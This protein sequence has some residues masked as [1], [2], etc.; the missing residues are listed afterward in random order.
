MELSLTVMVIS[1]VSLLVGIGV[2]ILLKGGSLMSI[3]D[4]VWGKLFKTPE[5]VAHDGNVST[6]KADVETVKAESSTM[7]ADIAQIKTDVAAMLPDVADLKTNLAAIVPIIVG[8]AA[9]FPVTADLGTVPEEIAALGMPDMS[10]WLECVGSAKVDN[11]IEVD[12]WS[13]FTVGSEVAAL[14]LNVNFDPAHFSFLVGQEVRGDDIVDWGQFGVNE[15]TP[16]QLIIGA[17]RNAARAIVGDKPVHLASF[18][19]QVTTSN[20]ITSTVHADNYVD[21]LVDCRPLPATAEILLN[22]N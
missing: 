1:F 15:A 16:G 22:E 20:F 5:F 21:A 9:Q 13:K 6:V 17:A 19:L 7:K 2:I 3:F 10:I 12:I 4:K 11:V 8:I 18:K 14:G